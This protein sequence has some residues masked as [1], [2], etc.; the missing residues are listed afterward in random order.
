M[1]AA[2]ADAARVRS[3]SPAYVE[4]DIPDDSPAGP[5]PDGPLSLSPTVVDDQGEAIG[6]ILIWIAGGRISLLEQPWYTDEPPGSWPPAE[7]VRLE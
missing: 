5:W 3:F 6:S 7:R 1:L 2:Q 4:V